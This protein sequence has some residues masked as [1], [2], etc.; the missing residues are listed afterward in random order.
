[1]LERCTALVVTVS[2]PSKSLLTFQTNTP[3]GT[4]NSSR[5]PRHVTIERLRATNVKTNLAGINSNYKDTATISGTCG[6]VAGE[7]CQQFNGVNKG[8]GDSKEIAGKQSCLGAQ[9]KLNRGTLP[10]C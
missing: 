6:T 4:N 1:M 7:I 3:A 5:G 9:G 8:Q 2:P 10:R